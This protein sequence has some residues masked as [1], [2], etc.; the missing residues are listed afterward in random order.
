MSHD[1][2]FAVS[3]F[4]NRNGA[5]S[6]RVSGTL[7]GV[8][9]RKNF[10]SREEAAAEKSTL[11]LRAAQ[12][13]SGQHVVATSLTI[14]QVR[15][16]ESA[17]RRLASGTPSLTFYLDYALTHYRA[18]DRDQPLAAAVAEYLASKGRESDQHLISACQ[19]NNIRKELALL[20]AHHPAGSVAQLTAV[21]LKAFCERGKPSLKSQN[22][23]RGILGTF[24][25]FA[26]QRDWI[27]QNPVDKVPHHRIAHRRGSAPTLTAKQAAAL[28]AHVEAQQGGA[29][30]PYFA[31]C[32]FA[33]IRPCVR[34]GEIL[35]LRPEHV[36]LETGVIHIEPEVSKVRMKRNVTIQP[37]LAVWLRAYPLDKFPIIIQ[38]NF[39][40]VRARIAKDFGLSHDIMRHTFISMHVAKFRSMGEAALQAGNSESIIRKHYLDLKTL[41]EADEFFSIMPKVQAMATTGEPLPFPA[42]GTALAATG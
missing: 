2:S 38:A 37:N 41:A 20:Q 21:Q 36:R 32:L 13:S 18:P 14:D 31:L 1:P 5:T 39:Q 30:V 24:F 40:N 6:W 26:F 28:M 23:R 7:A 22:N 17:F 34:S 3:R 16:A 4:E 11:E 35:K 42:H 29:L 19:V 12:A 27:A 25:K 15:E 8:R 9:I 33:G 10:P